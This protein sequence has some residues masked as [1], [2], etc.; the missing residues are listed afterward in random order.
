[1]QILCLKTLMLE[2]MMMGG[3]M[4]MTTT[5]ENW[6]G[7][8][9]GIDGPELMMRFQEHCQEFG[10]ETI[11]GEVTGLVDNGKEK[12]VTIDDGVISS[13]VED[14]SVTEQ[15]YIMPGFVDAHVH[16]ESSLLTPSEFARIAVT[17]GTV[18]TVSD[19]H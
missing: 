12:L 17:H 13:I 10:L 2:K 19:P 14:P 11:T 18:A 5:V 6:P 1:M 15:R 16:V 4:M 9:G 8:P 3:Q 7:Y